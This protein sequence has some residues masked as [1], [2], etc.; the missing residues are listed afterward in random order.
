MSIGWMVFLGIMFCVVNPL[1]LLSIREG[2]REFMPSRAHKRVVFI[3]FLGP[4]AWGVITLYMCIRVL[5]DFF[6]D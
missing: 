5:H 6:E 1:I 2:K 4:I 3:L